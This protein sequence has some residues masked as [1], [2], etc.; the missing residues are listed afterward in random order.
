MVFKGFW[1][2]GRAQGE[3]LEPL[4]AP[5]AS[6]GASWRLLGRSWVAVGALLGCL[7]AILRALGAVLDR[8][9]ELLG[10]LGAILG[11][12]GSE[13]LVLQGFGTPWTG[14]NVGVGVLRRRFWASRGGTIGGGNSNQR[15]ATED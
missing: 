4:G 15:P 10:P 14:E 9:W 12:L 8:S 6:S 2:W 13:T 7:G 5:G 1:G 3:L 11:A